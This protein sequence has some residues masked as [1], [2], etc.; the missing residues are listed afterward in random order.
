MKNNQ[1]KP[2]GIFLIVLGSIIALPLLQLI[3]SLTSLFVAFVLINYG[4]YIGG[5]PTLASLFSQWL[6]S[7][8]GIF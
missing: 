5:Y 6:K 3:L 7:I 1:R 4:L 8:R 2:V